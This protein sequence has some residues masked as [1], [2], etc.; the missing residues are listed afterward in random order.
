MRL[1]VSL[2]TIGLPGVINLCRC[3]GPAPLLRLRLASNV[4][5]SRCTGLPLLEGEGRHDCLIQFRLPQVRSAASQVQ[6]D[7]I[8]GDSWLHM[9]FHWQV[10]PLFLT[11]QTCLTDHTAQHAASAASVSDSIRQAHKTTVVSAMKQTVHLACRVRQ[12]EVA[13]GPAFSIAKYWVG[14]PAVPPLH[15]LAKRVTGRFESYREASSAVTAGCGRGA[16]GAR[17]TTRRLMALAP[18]TMP[19]QVRKK[20]CLTSIDTWPSPLACSGRS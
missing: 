12:P 10:Q 11:L 9:S 2:P 18:Q 15:M 14:G 7:C 1:L 6:C 8:S 3:R 20:G 16:A 5:A 4:L 19:I 13:D 17:S